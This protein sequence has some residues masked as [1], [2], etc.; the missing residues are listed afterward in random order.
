MAFFLIGCDVTQDNSDIK[1]AR[2]WDMRFNYYYRF[3]K[4][5]SDKTPNRVIYEKNSSCLIRI[6][7]RDITKDRE[8]LERKD[9]NN[10]CS[11]YKISDEE[12][13][14]NKYQ[15]CITDSH[16]KHLSFIHEDGK[17]VYEY[18]LILTGYDGDDE[19]CINELKIM[20]SS[21]TFR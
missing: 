1:S 9:F 11:R 7:Y 8:D 12:V 2:F 13:N 14:N 18:D 4:R 15:S 5:S 6:E 3:N 19:A 21:I 16:L 20:E 17:N 10:L